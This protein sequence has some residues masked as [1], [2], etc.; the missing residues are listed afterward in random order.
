MLDLNPVLEN[1]AW[2]GFDQPCYHPLL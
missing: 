1:K 2:T